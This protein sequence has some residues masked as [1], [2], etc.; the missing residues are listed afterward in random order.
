[1]K[2]LITLE[3]DGIFG[4]NFVYEGCTRS[5][6]TTAVTRLFFGR[7]DFSLYKIYFEHIGI[8]NHQYYFDTASYVAKTNAMSN[9]DVKCIAVILF[10]VSLD[11][12]HTQTHKMI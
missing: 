7:F 2:M 1:M 5:S 6:W 8:T 10:C 11:K 12:T 9:G 4:S 3:P